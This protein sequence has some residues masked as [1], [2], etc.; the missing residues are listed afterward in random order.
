MSKIATRIVDTASAV[1]T[2]IQRRNK[3]TL[4]FPLR[5]LSNVTYHPRKGFLQLRGK[6]KTRKAASTH[7]QVGVLVALRGVDRKG[8][9]S[10][11]IDNGWGTC[12]G[13]ARNLQNA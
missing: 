7:R 3:P 11:P 10:L 8:A 13:G 1:R 2:K 9:I 5:S 12:I 6:K 4:S